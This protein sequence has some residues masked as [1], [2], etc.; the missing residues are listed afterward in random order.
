MIDPAT[1]WL[2][3]AEMKVA[4]NSVDAFRIFNNFWLDKYPHPK[5]IIYDIGVELKKD[6]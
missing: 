5:K 1:G 4:N 3:I 6:F 2:E